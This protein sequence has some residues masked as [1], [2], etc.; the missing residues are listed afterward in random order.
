VE[1]PFAVAMPDWLRRRAGRAGNQPNQCLPSSLRTEMD[2]VLPLSPDYFFN[3]LFTYGILIKLDLL[4]QLVAG[5]AE[6]K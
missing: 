3:Q 4:H 5:W 6:K 2:G 1:A